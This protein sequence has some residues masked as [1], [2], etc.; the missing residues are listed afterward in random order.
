MPTFTL[1]GFTLN[2]GAYVGTT[3]FTVTVPENYLVNYEYSNATNNP[4]FATADFGVPA[5][6]IPEAFFEPTIN[7]PIFLAPYGEDVNDEL[8]VADVTFS[9]GQVLTMLSLYDASTGLDHVFVLADNF[10]SYSIPQNATEFSTAFAG[11]VSATEVTTGQFAPGQ[12]IDLANVDPT[13]LSSTSQDD[14]WIGTNLGE[15]FDGG[16]GNDTLNGADGNDTLRGGDGHDSLIGGDGRDVL[17]GNDGDDIIDASGGSAASQSFGDIILAGLGTNTVTGHAAAFSA[18]FGGGIDIIMADMGDA[19]GGVHITVSGM[20]GT[21]TAI[22][23]GSLAGQVST[24]FTFADHFEGSMGSDLIEGSDFGSGPSNDLESF[25]GG[26]GNDT[27]DGNGGFDVVQYNLEFAGT[28]GVDVDLASSVA[29]DSFGDTDTL[30]DIEGVEGTARGDTLRGDSGG[31]FLNGL[32]G[33]DFIEGRD[34]DDILLGGNGDDTLIGDLGD[35]ELNGGD[36]YDIARYDTAAGAVNV[37]LST[38]LA[39]GAHGNDS[40]IGIEEVEGS[41]FNDTLVGDGNDN[42]FVGRAGDDDIDGGAGSDDVY[43]YDASSAVF[44]D[45]T[46]GVS[47]LGGGNDTLTSIENVVGSNFADSIVGNADENRLRGLSGNDELFGRGGNDVLRGGAGNDT[48][49]GGTDDGGF[50]RGDR[51][52][53]SRDHEE[54]GTNGINADLA[55]G[56]ATDSFG[57]TDTLIDIESIRGTRHNDTLLG[58]GG[59]NQLQGEDGNDSIEGRDGDD[60][61]MGGA[62]ND[63]LIG[64]SGE[65]FLQAGAGVD[66]IEG[67]AGGIDTDFDELT[68]IFD[69]DFQNGQIAPAGITAVY[70]NA[71]DGTVVDFAGDT[72]TFTGI[73]RIG[74]TNND[75]SF[76]GSVGRQEFRGFGGNDTFNGGAGDNDV[77]D[78]S[79]ERADLGAS[80]GIDVNLALGTGTDA[81]GDTDTFSGIEEIWGTGFND[82][83]VGDTGR[84]WLEGRDGNDTL[85]GGDGDDGLVGGDGDDL[86]D[87]GAGAYDTAHYFDASGAVNANLTTGLASGAAG[88]DVLIGI[89]E[90]HGSDF[91]DTLIGDSG[92]NR[93]QGGLGDDSLDGGAGIDAVDYYESQ[94]GV[95][96]NLATGVVSGDRG[97][98]TITNF[99]NVWG[100]FGNDT[101]TGNAEDNV[102]QGRGGDDFIDG[103]AGGFDVVNFFGAT[104]GVN[105]NLATGSVTGGEGT[106]TLVNIEGLEGSAHNDTLIGDA[107]D[108]R[109]QGYFGDDS[110]DGGAGRDVVDYFQIQTGIS[111]N[112][113]TEVATGGGGNDT[114]IGFEDIY[115][116]FGDDTLVGT[117]GENLIIGRGGNDSIQLLDGNDF[118]DGGDGND[119]IDGGD[120]NDT[121]ADGLGDDSLIGGLG[122]D[123]F[124]LN[125]GSETVDGGMGS[126]TIRVD[127]SGFSLPSSFIA[128]LDLT[129]GY[130]GQQ[131]NPNLSETLISIE[132]LE[133]VGA[134]SVNAIGDG[135][136]NVFALDG[137]DDTVSGAGGEDTLFG[138]DGDDTIEGGAGGDDI[139]GGAGIDTG[140]YASSGAAVNV[141]LI[142]GTG[143]G[144]DAAGDV[145]TSVEN[146]LGSAFNDT[147]S[148]NGSANHLSGQMGND[149][150]RGGSGDDTL[151]GGQGTDDLSGGAGSDSLLGGNEADT[152]RGQGQND[153][154]DGGDGAD[155]ITGGAGAD[156]IDGGSGN[157]D[158]I[159]QGQGDTIN[160][161]AGNDTIS[162]G[163]GNDVLNGGSENDNLSGGGNNDTLNGDDGNDLLSG[164]AG[165]DELNGG[166]GDDT[167]NSGSGADTL[168]GGA[169]NDRMNGG[170]ADG[171]R[172]VFIFGLGY[173]ADRI[174]AFDQLGTDQLRLDD[175]LWLD[176]HP[177]GLTEQQVID[178]FGTLNGTGTILTLDFGGGDVLEVQNGAGID[179]ATLGADVFIF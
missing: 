172:D 119:T 144:G 36:G 40:L 67:G 128:E 163:S 177:G 147:F 141:S 6:A 148:G 103:G 136:N 87:G 174:N 56:L 77:V 164:A 114:V 143:L 161:G 115:A 71:T 80:Q 139:D 98:D 85:R 54:G 91:N 165:L 9:S 158:I 33:D 88:N 151:D 32:D 153:T 49:D 89:E 84:N 46:T 127:F 101:L 117:T 24:S 50:S 133:V 138:G 179:Q 106:D 22:G 21:G 55:T 42:A 41:D 3:T 160:G 105:A 10:N 142:A 166:S 171:V 52:D 118:G 29:T 73:E 16:A 20:Q 70:T 4:G 176:T 69:F 78:Y 94:S 2:A 155:D 27:I 37:N 23:T 51:A 75:D 76:T 149:T 57:N 86:L 92:R 159:G 134:V 35:D 100:G 116:G 132:G 18:S 11:I 39:S 31:N 152:L 111:V 109:I 59:R 124:L 121:I 68:Y 137:G 112:L 53:Y 30:L 107:G 14:F 47:F 81:F 63:T 135:E 48:L 13:T 104:S 79:R 145:L 150:L 156:S 12:D 167:L 72:D 96:V 65:D 175:A 58:D 108:N 83:I 38:G 178:T 129:T 140:S 122:D 99:E 1:E 7:T 113:T 28:Q 61:L 74:G 8:F 168:D 130:W 62:G 131:G 120:G 45:L 19:T 82:S 93:M 26:A 15:F 110:M 5:T 170:G 44:I 123:L 34:G 66:I 64:G 146:L 43:Y 125:S 97:N 102:L 162:G 169:G 157:D 173:E 154:I 60:D 17:E 126:D 25:V 95:S 90:L